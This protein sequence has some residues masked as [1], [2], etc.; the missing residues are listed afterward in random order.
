M[1]S[2]GLGRRLLVLLIILTIVHIVYYYPRMPEEMISQFDSHG[3]P[4][5]TMSRSAFFIIYAA[6]VVM[7]G[8]LFPGMGLL[9]KK[10]P[11][12]LI[13]LP[14]REYWFAPE[15]KEE[16]IR[17][18]NIYFVWFGNATLIFILLLM[19]YMFMVNLG[20]ESHFMIRFGWVLGIYL[21]FVLAWTGH[22]LIRF[23]KKPVTGSI[24]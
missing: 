7:M 17:V 22:L 13:N 11:V 10:I 1:E 3:Q 16:T 12:G 4:S 20:E 19:H 21:A 15:R 14:R 9:L 2:S 8:L 23:L 24:T 18:L 6:L 5:S